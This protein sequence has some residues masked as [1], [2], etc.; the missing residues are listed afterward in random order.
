MLIFCFDNLIHVVGLAN[1]LT[2]GKVLHTS[3][4]VSVFISFPSVAIILKC[5][6]LKITPCSP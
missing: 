6:T 2:V 4:F 3:V 5:A 1:P